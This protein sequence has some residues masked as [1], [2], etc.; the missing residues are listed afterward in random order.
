MT[1]DVAGACRGHYRQAPIFW[2]I[3]PLQPVGFHLLD[4]VVNRILTVILFALLVIPVKDFGVQ[5][6]YGAKLRNV[7]TNSL[8]DTALHNN[9]DVFAWLFLLLL[10]RANFPGTEHLAAGDPANILAEGQVVPVDLRPWLA[11]RD[12]IHLVFVDLDLDSE[13][14]FLRHSN[15]PF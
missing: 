14:H 2:L 3:N 5:Q 10:L 9:H 1:G 4:P 8:N 12:M 13:Y 11:G 6:R 15:L 7:R